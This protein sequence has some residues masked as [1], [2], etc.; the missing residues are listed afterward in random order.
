MV[1]MRNEVKKLV[2]SVVVTA[3]VVLLS[4]PLWNYANTNNGL[5]LASLYTNLSMSVKVGRFPSLLVIEDEKAIENIQATKVQVRNQNSMKKEYN[6]YFYIDKSTTIDRN[7]LRVSIGND[8]Y[9]LKEMDCTETN[10]GYYYLVHESTIE[11][12]TNE[13]LEA[14]IW[15]TQ[16]GASLGD[17]AKLVTNFVSKI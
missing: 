14:R 12:Y 6:L 1:D 8:I 16:E 15:L 10:D 7:F 4:I 17:D 13:D 2:V 9:K 3:L 5:S 11:A